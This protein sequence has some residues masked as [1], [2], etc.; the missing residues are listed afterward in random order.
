MVFLLGCKWQNTFPVF[1]SYYVFSSFS[2]LDDRLHLY[3]PHMVFIM[4]V[5]YF[6]VVSIHILTPNCWQYSLVPK[7]Y[8]NIGKYNYESDDSKKESGGE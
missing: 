2:L 6:K 3:K 1:I 8:Y 4:T 5:L 7:H